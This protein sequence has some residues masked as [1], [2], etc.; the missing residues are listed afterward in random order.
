MSQQGVEIDLLTY[1]EGQDVD[2]PGVRIVRT[3]RFAWLGKVKTGPSKLKIFLDI[4]VSIWTVGLLIKNR[5]DF[6]H[7]HEEAVFVAIFLKPLFRFKLIYDMHS[8]LPEQL[9]N[10]GW[11]NS[12]L[13]RKMVSSAEN[14]ALRRSEAVITICP[15]LSEHALTLIDNP[16]KHFLIENSIFEPV[17]L[18]DPPTADK[19]AGE[20]DSV[21]KTLEEKGVEITMLYAGTL[22]TYQ[23]IDLL[24]ES[25]TFVKQE[26]PQAHLIVVGGS[27]EQVT[28]YRQLSLELQIDDVCTFTARVPQATA[29]AFTGRA[30]ILTSPRSRGMNT[31]LKVY[32]LLDCGKPLVATR[33]PSHTQV[34]TDAVSFLGDPTPRDFATQLVLAATQEDLV[35]EKITN[36]RKLYA[37]DYSPVAYGQKIEALLNLIR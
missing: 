4:F 14:S 9:N 28:A 13:L 27:A 26:C 33:I 1:G 36:A 11:T 7:A 6:V 10:F 30:D 21:F 2:I 34:L 8:S 25:M 12:N 18:V 15:A 20:V 37:D 24:L 17:K 5:Y 16:E 31:P 35:S 19:V 3:P 23:G 32:E 29:K 22:E